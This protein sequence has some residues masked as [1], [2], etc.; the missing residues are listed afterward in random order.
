MATYLVTGGAGFIGSHIASHL[1]ERGETVRVLDD[2]STGKKENI[3][4]L[5]D[6]VTLFT[7]DI[8][9]VDCV[10]EAVDGV[11]YVLNQAALPSVPRSIKDP[12]STNNTNVKG[13]L[14]LLVESTKAGV[15]RFVYASSSSVY[16]N[17][18]S[19]PVDESF[20]AD[21]RSPYAVTKLANE[22]YGKIYSSIYGLET[23]GLR[24]FNVFGPGQDSKSQYSAVIPIF[25]SK[26]LNNENPV[27]Y[28]DG[29][30]SRDFTYIDNVV[31]AN[32][33][34]VS[35]K[36]V[37][38]EVFNIACGESLSINKMLDMFRSY[39]QVDIK[40]EYAEPRMGDVRKSFA[41]ISKAEKLLGYKPLISFKDGLK[42]TLDW[43][44]ANE[45]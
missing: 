20:P 39:F 45:V 28:S 3:G 36:N 8:C 13:F 5:K 12:I 1:V 10:R 25:A 18:K 40:P 2:F 38:G 19:M 32:L 33:L 41:N 26:I 9:D 37:A 43:Y 42:K 4:K 24:Y 14:N 21:P 29:E 16:G 7:G 30:Q 44:K 17:A 27:I 35:A 15:K 31:Q 22:Y 6:S 11:D 34:A 23:V